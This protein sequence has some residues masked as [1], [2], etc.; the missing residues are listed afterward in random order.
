M[1]SRERIEAVIKGCEPDRI[2][3]V[4]FSSPWIMNYGG[5]KFIECLEKPDRFIQA[6][7]KFI[8]D[9]GPDMVSDFI[10]YGAVIEAV[11]ASLAVTEYES[12]TIPEKL[13]IH[14]LDDVKALKPMDLT[15][16]KIPFLLSLMT[17]LRKTVPE[18]IPVI[19]RLGTPFRGGNLIRGVD[20]FM[21]DMIT[22]PDLIHALMDYL[23][24]QYLTYGKG[25][26][27]AGAD[28]ILLTNPHANATV[29]SRK[30]YETF[31][32]PYI[33]RLI[34][35]LKE[36]GTIVVF[37]TCGKWNDR[38]DL[39]IEEGADIYFTDDV[40][41]NEAKR[42]M[43]SRGAVMGNV[44]VVQTMLQSGRDEV[45]QE[46]RRCIESTAASGRFILSGNCFLPRDVP[47]E[48]VRALFEAGQQFGRYPLEL[49]GGQV[50][51]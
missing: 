27:D 3:I 36:M 23:T 28:A 21:M 32:H 7:M 1:T 37:H 33:K 46:A 20:N 15:C 10:G 49:F 39:V 9:F 29:I 16:G 6:T 41:M 50:S 5:T 2:P 12:P 30:Q 17:D 13:L 26:V 24:D 22:D 43:G 18:E 51:S 42:L 19:G 44:N 11:G 35:G 38:L 45:F 34:T 14:S 8:E 25:L 47:V 40:D 4:P 31:S 48:N